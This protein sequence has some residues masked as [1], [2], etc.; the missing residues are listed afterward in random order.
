MHAEHSVI[1]GIRTIIMG[2]IGQA[3][4]ISRLSYKVSVGGSVR[5]YAP[6]R[7]YTDGVFR[8][9]KSNLLYSS[10]GA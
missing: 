3:H 10:D 7:V 5:G 1:K 4:K 2:H 9:G 6:K 8:A